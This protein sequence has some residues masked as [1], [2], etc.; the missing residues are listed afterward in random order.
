MS[1]Y[2]VNQAELASTGVTLKHF[3][4]THL[5]KMEIMIP[6][7]TIQKQIVEKIEAE[8]ALIESAK[9]L[10]EIYEQKTKDVIAKLWSE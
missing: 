7:I 10:I 2:F 6:P 9:K 8:R 4:P 5:N 1:E 3:G